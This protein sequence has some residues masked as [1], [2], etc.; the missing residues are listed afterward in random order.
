MSEL[1][2]GSPQTD[3]YVD[4]YFVHI[5]QAFDSGERFTASIPR[6]LWPL[7]E[8]SINRQLQETGA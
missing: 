3:V 2:V 1:F 5:E 4:E 7:I 8:A 6:Y